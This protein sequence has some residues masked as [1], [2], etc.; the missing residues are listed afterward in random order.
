[1]KWPSKEVK[2]HHPEKPERPLL[3]LLKV[4]PA[5]KMASLPERLEKV[6]AIMFEW[7]IKSDSYLC[8]LTIGTSDFTDS[9]KCTA[10]VLNGLALIKQTDSECSRLEPQ[11]EQM[12]PR[13]PILTLTQEQGSQIAFEQAFSCPHSLCSLPK[14]T[15]PLFGIFKVLHNIKCIS[16]TRQAIKKFISFVTSCIP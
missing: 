10:A 8:M 11:G 4:T 13:I 6:V 12:V 16:Q 2:P 9:N 3:D 14:E 1:M 15:P 7:I 5:W